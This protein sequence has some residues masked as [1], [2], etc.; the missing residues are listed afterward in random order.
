MYVDIKRT[1]VTLTKTTPDNGG[2]D[3]LQNVECPGL[4]RLA[5]TRQVFRK[6]EISLITN[7]HTLF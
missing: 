4:F 3:S 2:T 6:T 1:T 7:T 5:D